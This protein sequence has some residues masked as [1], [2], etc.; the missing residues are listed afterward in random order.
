M[1]ADESTVDRSN[2]SPTVSSLPDFAQIFVFLQVFGVSLNLPPVTIKELED[3]FTYGKPLFF[4]CLA[5]F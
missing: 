3:F 1:E 4:E 2:E 5:D